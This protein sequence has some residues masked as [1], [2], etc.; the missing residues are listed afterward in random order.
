[1]FELKLISLN[2]E[3]EFKLDTKLKLK[4]TNETS[5]IQAIGIF[6]KPE[7]EPSLNILLLL[8]S[9]PQPFIRVI[10]VIDIFG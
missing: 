8:S 4:L 1:M 3:L 2:I 9:R 6:D 10:W 7:L 5:R